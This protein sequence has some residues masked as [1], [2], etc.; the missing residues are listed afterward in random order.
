MSVGCVMFYSVVSHFRIT[1]H[2]S[3][4]ALVRA[5]GSSADVQESLPWSYYQGLSGGFA[6][7][8][9]GDLALVFLPGSEWEYLGN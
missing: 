9:G 3:V 7:S 5:A 1:R 2:S 6:K 8:H 4:A